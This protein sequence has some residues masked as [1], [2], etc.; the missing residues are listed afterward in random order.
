[1]INNNTNPVEWALLMYELEDAKEHLQ[2][3]IDEMA[4]SRAFDETDFRIQL[5]HVYAHLNRSWNARNYEGEVSDE[6]RD[7]FS[8]FPTDLEP[9]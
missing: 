2:D 5:G 3:L 8:S 9:I 4:D 6:N 7:K 1:M